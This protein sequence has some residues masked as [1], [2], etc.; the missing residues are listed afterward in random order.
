MILLT[1]RIIKVPEHFIHTIAPRIAPPGD[2]FVW[3]R[4]RYDI[5]QHH[6]QRH[7]SRFF[8][9]IGLRLTLDSDNVRFS[10]PRLGAMLVF[11]LPYQFAMKRRVDPQDYEFAQKRIGIDVA[12]FGDQR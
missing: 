2:H 8:V 5:G 1:Y 11:E 4:G 9:F 3:Q 6:I 12:R 7:Q 10:L